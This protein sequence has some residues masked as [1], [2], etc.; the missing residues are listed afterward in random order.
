MSLI[1]TLHKGEKVETRISVDPGR[2]LVDIRQFERITSTGVYTIGKAGLSVSL[3]D[4]DMFIAHLTRAKAE[5]VNLVTL[6]D[7]RRKE[8]GARDTYAP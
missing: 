5:V 3:T 2:N 6:Q 1:G 7:N 4:I 8:G